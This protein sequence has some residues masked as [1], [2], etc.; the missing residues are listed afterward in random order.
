MPGYK[1]LPAF[2]TGEAADQVREAEERHRTGDSAAA[3]QLLEEALV[4]SIAVRPAFPG[5]L[6]GR[7]AALYRSVG[8]YD[9]EVQ[10]LERYRDSQTSED[11]RTRYGARLCKARTIADR[12]RRTPSGA[13]D[14]VR[15][16]LGRPRSRRVR[17]RAAVSPPRLGI[18]ASVVVELTDAVHADA[19]RH[20]SSL[21]AALQRL[22]KE[23]REA[24]A[25]AELLVA[26]LKT[27][28]AGSNGI[29]ALFGSV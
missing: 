10:L 25:P 17:S 23:G 27:A 21:R 18:S 19:A 8:R 15:A 14:S 5:W 12:K 3:V 1:S 11:A 4:A 2:L 9:D 22:V 29:D 13:L 20:P 24:H 6:C 7:L 16:S 26:A 28:S